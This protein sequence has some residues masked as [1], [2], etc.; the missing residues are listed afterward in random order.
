MLKELI[1]P[2]MTAL[3]FASSS[4]YISSMVAKNELPEEI[5]YELPKNGELPEISLKAEKLYNESW[6]LKM[7]VSNFTFT[8]ICTIEITDPYIG[9]AHIFEDDVWLGTSFTPIFNLGKLEPGKHEFVVSLRSQDHRTLVGKNGV[10]E[11]KIV[12]Y[13]EEDKVQEPE[14]L[15]N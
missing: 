1:L 8:E 15:V 9:H 6:T 13:V 4:F 3:L 12:I 2:A 5:F 10:I 11:Q 7:D 14:F